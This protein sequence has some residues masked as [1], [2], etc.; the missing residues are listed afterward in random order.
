MR[1]MYCNI[2]IFDYDQS[3]YMLDG[4]NSHLIARV[5]FQHLGKTMPELCY[6]NN[7][8]TVKLNCSVPGMAQQAAD[9]IYTEAA[10]KYGSNHQIDI[11]VL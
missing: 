2:N 6:S 1:V 8:Y 10:K 11:E 3:I 4:D 7:I 9:A 5:P